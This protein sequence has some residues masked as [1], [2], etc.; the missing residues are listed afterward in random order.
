MSENH[1]LPIYGE[2]ILSAKQMSLFEKQLVK[3]SPDLAE[4]FMDSAAMGMFNVLKKRVLEKSSRKNIVLLIGKGNNG[5][6]AYTLGSLLVQ[7][8]WE[9]E[10]FAL[11]KETSELSAKRAAAFHR[12]GGRIHLVKTITDF[13]L[14][15]NSIVID[16]LLGTGCTGG[17]FGLLAE[18][19][20]KVNSSECFVFSIDIASGVDGNTGLVQGNAIC[21]DV[22]AY[23][24]ALKVGHLFEKGLEYS[25]VFHY[26][27]F[28]LDCSS[29]E[30]KYYLFNANELQSRLPKRSLLGNKYDVGQVVALCGNS[31][32][33]GAAELCCR[34]AYRAG[35][36]IVRHFYLGDAPCSMNEVITQKMSIE[37]FDKELYRTK[38][39]VIGPGLGRD[40]EAKAVVKYVLQITDIAMVIDA[41][42]LFLLETPPM[43]A[44]LTPHRGELL[45]LL[46]MGKDSQ[47]EQIHQAAQCYADKFS[48]TIIFK[49]VPTVIFSP[50]G[51][52]IVIVSGNPGMSSGGTGDVLAGIVASF[53]AQ[54]AN[55]LDA[56]SLGVTVHGKAAD[57][58]ATFLSERYMVA[59][60]IIN[61]L[62]KVFL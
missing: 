10:A 9:V 61:Y 4:V 8:G 55:P 31:S 1:K 29:L 28:G 21:A 5:A 60:D 45:R 59:S 46:G 39:I 50:R 3:K 34:A 25:G 27:D 51:K 30:A 48:V 43:H 22:T 17:V 44:I 7:S 52:K 62:S 15:E 36:G 16:G 13:S 49:G 14:P 38:A 18:V 37:L 58:A 6:D 2:K 57:L 42:A 40:E 54:G 47:D 12:D 26:V 56:A 19:V 24:G 35:C 41:D 32:M 23:L 53:L 33:K 20:E 11:F